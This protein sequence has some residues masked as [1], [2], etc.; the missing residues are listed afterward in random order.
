MSRIRRAFGTLAIATFALVG[1]APATSAPA[2]TFTHYGPRNA[3]AWALSRRSVAGG[4]GTLP[5]EYPGPK[6]WNQPAGDYCT[7]YKFAQIQA[8]TTSAPFTTVSD[9]DLGSLTG[10]DRGAP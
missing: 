6:T 2:A 7:A 1:A 3:G 5:N 9:T 4:S 10:F 8:P